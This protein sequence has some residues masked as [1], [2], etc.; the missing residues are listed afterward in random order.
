MNTDIRENLS[1]I[2]NKKKERIKILKE[3]RD[4]YKREK[5][6]WRKKK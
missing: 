4:R 1:Q 6:K 5:K 2:E 3:E